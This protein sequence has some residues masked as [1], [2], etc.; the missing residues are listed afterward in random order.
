MTETLKPGTPLPWRVRDD[1]GSWA[2][3]ISGDADK[4]DIAEVGEGWPASE[5]ADAEKDAAYIVEACNAYPGLIEGRDLWKQSEEIFSKQYDK[6]LAMTAELAEALDKLSSN[7]A[8]ASF[9]RNEY[10]KELR[11]TAAAALAR[12]RG[13]GK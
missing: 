8:A 6:L 11:A 12:Y 4:A 10:G 13:E 2:T 9:A 5:M 3:W 1:V 7:I